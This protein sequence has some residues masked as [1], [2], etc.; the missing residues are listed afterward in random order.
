MRVLRG[1]GRE[2]AEKGRGEGEG[3]EGRHWME[4]GEGF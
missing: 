3:R 2:G 1:G 4:K